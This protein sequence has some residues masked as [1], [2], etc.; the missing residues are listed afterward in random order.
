M[1]KPRGGRR[2][3]QPMNQ[4]EPNIDNTKQGK[5]II[6]IQGKVEKLSIYTNSNTNNNNINNT[7][8]II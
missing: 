7:F 5:E 2:L 3:P 8:L 6:E 1:K 4:D